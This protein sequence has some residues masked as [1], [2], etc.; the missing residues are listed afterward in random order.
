MATA[1]VFVIHLYS[2]MRSTVI[3][4]RSKSRTW[5]LLSC[6]IYSCPENWTVIEQERTWPSGNAPA[7]SDRREG[8][9]TWV[10]VKVPGPPPRNRVPWRGM[11][12]DGLNQPRS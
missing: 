6:E 7:D 5:T 3:K 11:G 1:E 4:Q 10:W 9:F 12:V 2:Q 8:S